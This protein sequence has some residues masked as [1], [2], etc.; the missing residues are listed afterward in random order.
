SH[1]GIDAERHKKLFPMDMRPQAHDIIRTWAFVT[2]AKAWLHEREI[3]WKH[4]V[5][6]GWILDPD[7]KKMSKSKGNVVTP[8]HLLDEYSSDGVRYWASKARLGADTAFDVGVFKI[9]Q[10]LVTKLFNASR[11]VFSHLERTGLNPLDIQVSNIQH[12]LDCTLIEQLRSVIAESTEAFE[13]FDYAS[14]LQNT[15][16]AFWSFCDNYLELVK[17][18]SYL[19]EDC[20]ERRSA[21][22]TLAWSLKSFLRLFDPFLPYVTEELWSTS[23]AGTGN[24]ASVHT[25]RWP[26]VEEIKEVR[27]PKNKKSWE[28]IVDVISKVRGAKTLAQKSLK[29]PVKKLIIEGSEESCTALSTV[30]GDLADGSNVSLESINLKH[31]SDSENTEGLFNVEVILAE[32]EG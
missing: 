16:E 1:W 14:A 18:R 10:K 24:S 9:G 5:I 27:T 2:I 4:A 20:P 8:S 26:T 21:M 11:F 22:A 13:K 17:K 3:P 25:S 7:R 12:E 30:L 31:S 19:E 28:A 6:S 32:Q 29:W 23:F 15:E